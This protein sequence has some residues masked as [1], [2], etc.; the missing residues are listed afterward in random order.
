MTFVVDQRARVGGGPGIHALLLGVSAYRHL[1]T[2]PDPEAADTLRLGQLSCAAISAYR[3]AQWLQQPTGHLA[4]PLITLRLLI[5]PSEA[6]LNAEP[7]LAALEAG[8]TLQQV[9]EAARDWSEDASTHPESIA[10]FYFG[11]HGIQRSKG[12][13]VL[14]LEDFA[15]G[16]G[17]VLEK[18]ISA[19]NVHNGMAPTASPHRRCVARSQLYL[20]DACRVDSPR[21]RDLEATDPSVLWTTEMGGVD[22]RRA[23][24]FFATVP[25]DA[26]YGRPAATTLF[27]DA[28]IACLEGGAAD[29]LEIDGREAWRVGAHGL[30]SALSEHLPE[31]ANQAGVAQE[32]RADGM[33]PNFFL[34]ELADPPAVPVELTIRPEDAIDHAAV[35]IRNEEGDAACEVPRPLD[36]HPYHLEL[37]AGYYMI[38]ADVVPPD[39]R[40]QPRAPYGRMVKPP[41]Y[42][43]TI[44]LA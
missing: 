5:S 3:L 39:A 37:P 9:R 15:D 6:E 23:P 8:C 41:R 34:H 43:H 17:G 13:C 26:A 12:D 38:G 42:P 35:S 32:Y 40:F 19:R 21:L 44:Q 30:T 31:L 22:D 1:P 10:I 24:T 27:M 29:L 28:L 20:L 2:Q 25:G 4:L 18:A 11:G 16:E 7:E 36:P 14:L 33:G